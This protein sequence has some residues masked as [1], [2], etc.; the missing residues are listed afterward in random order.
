MARIV[1]VYVLLSTVVGGA[2][3]GGFVLRVEDGGKG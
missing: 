3:H 1:S 2:L